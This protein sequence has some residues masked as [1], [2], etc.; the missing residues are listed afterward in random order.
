[1]RFWTAP[2]KSRAFNFL[3]GSI[4][5]EEAPSLLR[6]IDDAAKAYHL[7]CLSCCQVFWTIAWG[8]NMLIPLEEHGTDMKFGDVIGSVR[9]GSFALAPHWHSS[10]VGKRWAQETVRYT[11]FQDTFHVSSCGLREKHPSGASAQAPPDLSS[12]D[13]RYV[14]G[15]YGD[16]A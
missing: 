10:K 12:V 2:D 11:P 9:D 3:R 4:G 5:I 1:M 7:W 13:R 14:Q 15:S 8:D 6:I 16:H